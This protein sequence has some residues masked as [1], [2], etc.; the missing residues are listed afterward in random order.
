MIDHYDVLDRETLRELRE[1]LGPGLTLVL[2]QFG[3]QASG[4]LHSLEQ[5]ATSGDMEAVRTLAHRLKGSAGSIG[6]RVLAA[7]A[8]QL[9]RMAAEG[10][11]EGVR[12]KLEFLPALI[13]RTVQALA[14]A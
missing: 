7:E 6:A 3:G 5:K 1:M 4:L 2:D 11:T 9:E 8:A 13:T 12:A 14:S 10:D